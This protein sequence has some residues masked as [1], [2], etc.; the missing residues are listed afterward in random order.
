MI[1]NDAERNF[2]EKNISHL[3]RIHPLVVFQ[4]IY[5]Y[6]KISESSINLQR[7]AAYENLKKDSLFS[8]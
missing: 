8:T 3:F 7:L 2:S 6:F 5:K 4:K 1:K